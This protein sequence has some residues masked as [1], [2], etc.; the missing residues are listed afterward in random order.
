MSP[1]LLVS[2]HDVAPGSF[3]QSRRWLTEVE[4]YGMRATLLVIPGAWRGAQMR[5]RDDFERWLHDS[6]AAGHEI[7]LHGW[8]HVAVDDPSAPGSFFERTRS[9][10]RA[11]GC[12]EFAGLGPVEARRRLELGRAVLHDAGFQPRGFI[13]PGWLARESTNAVLADLGFEYTATQWS[14]IDLLHGARHSIP[15]TSQRPNSPVTGAAARVNLRLTARWL[16][17]G[18]PLRMALHPDDL[19]DRLLITSTRAML[20]EAIRHGYQAN[21]Y[22][23]HV[24]QERVELMPSLA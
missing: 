23:R 11:R 7:A 1:T 15:S 13:P 6:E 18:R 12:A 21:T 4:R 17:T 8:E 14:V 22:G 9:A 24:A 5:A 10:V 20:S 2:L 16:A 19:N 3:A